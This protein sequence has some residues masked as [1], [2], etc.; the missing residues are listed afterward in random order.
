MGGDEHKQDGDYEDIHQKKSAEA[1]ALL[2]AQWLAGMN[3]FHKKM[4]QERELVQQ[5]D[6]EHEQERERERERLSCEHRLE[7]PELYTMG[8]D[9][10]V[11]DIG[12]WTVKCGVAD[13]TQELFRTSCPLEGG[14]GE[15]WAA[16]EKIWHHVFHSALKVDPKDHPVLLTMGPLKPKSDREKVCQMMFEVFEVPAMF[17]TTPAALALYF[18]GGCITGIAVD[19][20]HCLSTAVPIFEGHVL[21]HA[22]LHL[23]VGGR[24]VTN[25]LMKIMYDR[26]DEQ[27]TCFLKEKYC[28]VAERYDEE[29]QYGRECTV[30]LPNGESLTLGSERIT[31]SE[32]LFKPSLLGNA[33]SGIHEVTNESIQKCDVGIQLAL[34]SHVVLCGGTSGFSGLGLRLNRELKACAPVKF[35]QNVH[36]IS[37][38]AVGS[39]CT[40]RGGSALASGARFR[41]LLLSKAYYERDG[42]MIVHDCDRPVRW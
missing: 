15:N 8:M 25:H 33:S 40:W 12:S 31:C 23:D 36:V 24:D 10:I 7:C 17:V 1:G 5:R 35:E 22:V 34:Y 37:T 9:T 28:Y 27:T 21:P 20:G 39:F 6:R 30:E 32:V 38:H 42:P 4:A 19:C 3:E 26:Q 16:S 29:L 41:E 13:K 18:G 2:A 14:I 11:C